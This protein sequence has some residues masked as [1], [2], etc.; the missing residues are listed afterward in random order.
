MFESSIR[1]WT[2][3]KSVED[4]RENH[5]SNDVEVNAVPSAALGKCSVSCVCREPLTE[6]F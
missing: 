6:A 4:R 3:A 5:N 2:N 1:P